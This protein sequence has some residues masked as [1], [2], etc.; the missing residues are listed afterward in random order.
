MLT[1]HKEVHQK[2]VNNPNGEKQFPTETL[3]IED[4]VC[5]LCE[6][7]AMDDVNLEAHMKSVHG[8]ESTLSEDVLTVKCKETAAHLYKCDE[9]IFTT[10][11]PESF[12]DHKTVHHPKSIPE[13]AAFLHSCITCSFKTN[14]YES[15][16]IHIIEKHRTVPKCDVCDYQAESLD[17]IKTHKSLI[18]TP[19]EKIQCNLCEFAAEDIAILKGHVEINHCSN[20]NHY[21]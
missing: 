19:E 16:N 9:C 11:T 18:H 3:L 10:N 7:K 6:F 15:L 20:T 12:K 1:E 2:K 21:I 4:N 14:E 13:Q 5:A 8:T 17:Q